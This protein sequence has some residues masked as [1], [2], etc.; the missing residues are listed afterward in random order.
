TGAAG[1]AVYV[2][3]RTVCNIPKQFVGSFF[4]ALSPELTALEVHGANARLRQIHSLSAKLATG[5]ALCFGVL[6]HFW[7]RVLVQYWTGGSLPFDQKVLDAL[8]F[9]SFIQ[10]VPLPSATLL[11]AANRHQ[12]TAK[13]QLA[14]SIIGLIAGWRLCALYGVS[15]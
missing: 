14:A 5:V 1:V 15:G 7:G 11:T 12:R 6:A 13:V 4:S 2:T 3:L 10:I 9:L 8:L